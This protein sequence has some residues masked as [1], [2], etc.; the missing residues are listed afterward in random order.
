MSDPFTFNP[1]QMTWEITPDTDGDHLL[2]V[3][4]TVPGV[5]QFGRSTYLHSNPTDD[6]YGFA[7]ELAMLTRD[8]MFSFTEAVEGLDQD[9]MD[10]W[11]ASFSAH[12]RLA[13]AAAAQKEGEA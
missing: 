13:I 8:V 5:R 10:A 12:E 3:C 1:L 7:D 4:Y 2:F 6:I 11:L 9:E